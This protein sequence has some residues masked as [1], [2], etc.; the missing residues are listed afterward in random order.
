MKKVL[1]GI[2]L[3]VATQSSAFAGNRTT[4]PVSLYA[5][6][7]MSVVASGVASVAAAPAASAVAVIGGA[8]LTGSIGLAS[9]IDAKSQRS[10][11]LNV[12]DDSIVSNRRGD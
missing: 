5:V 6:P 1:I 12:D 7:V 3:L 8:A 9:H 2:A 11:P 10:R 4:L